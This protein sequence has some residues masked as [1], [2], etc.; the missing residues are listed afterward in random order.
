M[1]SENLGFNFGLSLYLQVIFATFWS[2]ILTIFCHF[3]VIRYFVGKSIFISFVFGSV[4]SNY[5]FLH[6]ENPEPSIFQEDQYLLALF[7]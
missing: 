6:T 2:K 7:I 5:L 1:H 4:F 3:F